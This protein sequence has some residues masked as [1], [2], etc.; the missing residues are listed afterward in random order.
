MLITLLKDSPANI[1]KIQSL[2]QIATI[3]TNYYHYNNF[4]TYT[5]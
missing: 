2:M 1:L 4:E 5:N 3:D